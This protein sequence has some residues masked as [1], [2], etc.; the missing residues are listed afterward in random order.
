MFESN[1]RYYTLSTNTVITS[2]GNSIN[3][4]SRRFLPK[5]STQANYAEVT[6]V[7]GDRL[8]NIAARTLG[9]PLAYWQIADLNQVMQPK[10]LTQFPGQ[11]IRIPTN[12]IQG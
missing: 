6:Y 11:I 10:T 4:K 3:Y 12:R 8:D 1:S 5:V 2:D 7:E 9:N